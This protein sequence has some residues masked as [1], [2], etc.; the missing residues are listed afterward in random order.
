VEFE[1]NQRPS[2]NI[3]KIIEEERKKQYKIIG[4]FDGGYHDDRQ[5]TYKEGLLFARSIMRLLDEN[6]DLFVVFKEKKPR[7]K[8]KKYCPALS[9]VYDMLE[10]HPRTHFPSYKITPS[11]VSAFSD[12]IVSFPFT[13]STVEAISAGKKAVYFDPSGMLKNSYYDKF[14][15]FLCHGYGEL[16]NT[17]KEM[18]S[19]S[20]E[21]HHAYLDKHI[22][23][24]IEPYLDGKAVTRMRELLVKEERG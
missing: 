2:S 8:I 18:L 20:D 4:V 9:R 22:K 15:N 7:Y 6:D 12:L 3:K 24:L 1:K 16:E 11:E 17:V 21:S 10:A 14:P 5:N 13:S 23:P 19:Q